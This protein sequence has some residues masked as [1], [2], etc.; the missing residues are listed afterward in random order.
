MHIF[1]NDG[2]TLEA[3]DLPFDPGQDTAPLVVLSY[4]DSDLGA[5]E[6]AWHDARAAGAPLPATRLANLVALRHPVSVDQYVDNTLCDARAILIRLIGGESYWSYG[7]SR[8]NALATRR[9]IALAV[10]PA[11]GRADPRL[12]ALSTLSEPTL[13]RLAR[14]CEAGGAESAR[15]ALALLAEAAGLSSIPAVDATPLPPMGFYRHDRGPLVE[16]A[17]DGDRPLV[18]VPFYR[19]HLAAADVRPIDDLLAGF[20]AHGFE[21][22]G[23]FAT[24]LKASGIGESLERIGATPLAVVN[25]TNFS[26]RR[27]PL[28]SP[29]DRFGCPVFQVSMSTGRRRDWHASN[30]GLSAS[31]L[32]M[33]VVLPEVDGRVFAGTISFK[34]PTARDPDLQYSRFRHR[35]DPVLVDQAVERVVRH[36]RLATRPNAEKRLAVVLSSYPGRPHQLAHAVG[37][38]TFAS[39][40]SLA[41]DLAAAGYDI[42][43]LSALPER[44]QRAGASW[45]LEDYRRAFERLPAELRTA[46]LD[47]YGPADDDPAVRDGAFHWTAMRAG[48]AWIA[49]QP[50]RGDPARKDDD[51]HDLTMPPRHAYIAF[52]LWLQSLGLDAVVHM[53]AHGTL[54]WL[55]GKSVALSPACW[56]DALLARLPMIYP[57]ILNDPGEAAHA[58]RRLGALTIGHLPPPLKTATV[59]LDLGPLER[60]LDEYATA[61]GIDPRRRARLVTAIREEA[62]ATGVEADLGIAPDAS[63][64]EAVGRIDRFVCTLKS[65]RFGDGLHVFGTGACGAEERAGVLDALSGRRVPPGPAGSPHRDRSDVL[66]TGRNL[67]AID[68]RIVPSANAEAEGVR[69]GQ[70]LLRRHLQDH[71][72][73]PASVVVDLWGSATMRTAGEEFAMALHLAGASVRR[74]EGT[75]RVSGFEVIP[76]AVLGRPRIDVTLRVSGLFRDVFP[77]LGELFDALTARLAELRDEA[78]N[79]YRAVAARVFG[80]RPGTY[81]LGL[82]DVTASFGQDARTAAGRAWIA[83]SSWTIRADGAVVEDRTAIE[84]RLRAADAFVHVQDLPESDVLLAAD[85]AAHEGGFAAAAEVLTGRTPTL[86]HLDTTESGHPQARQLTEEIARVVRAR[87]ANPDW[88]DGLR[89]HGFRGAAE[90]VATVEHLA[91]FAQLADVVPA[92]LFD[93]CFEATLGRAAVRDFLIDENP[94]AH[95]AL[96]SLFRRLHEAG[97]WRSRR[98]DLVARLDGLH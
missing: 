24:S 51:Y 39:T 42:P 26:A 90:I 13:E 64:P 50:D 65:S 96:Q 97:R 8:V 80:P 76:R 38:D 63:A 15:A 6:N 28:P 95:E 59:P 11:D 22:L 48:R 66:P 94:A 86:Y 75:G 20:E 40:A 62:R 12:S 54:E 98:N 23:F 84:A 67:Y 70:E 71:G 17:V 30:R 19:S 45:S 31:D 16:P 41:V 83:A 5:F 44:L 89:R 27:G 56:P 47:R 92:H 3:T 91:A 74:D 73:W 69:M 29:L 58:K 49:V 9:K 34:S 57:F 18:L 21:A 85:Y 7:L 60:L 88:A 37:L 87:A 10:L 77:G 14:H 33:Q 46:A 1:F 82:G 55:P 2:P 68:P 79:P 25:A 61:D 52:H 78:D 93:R 43:A 53:G 81:G 35:S 32:A 36:A 4:S 72:D